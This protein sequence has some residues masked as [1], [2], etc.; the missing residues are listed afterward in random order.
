M[1]PPTVKLMSTNLPGHPNVFGGYICL[2]MLKPRLSTGPYDGWTSAYTT[3]SIL[4]QLQSFLLAEG[5]IDQDVGGKVKAHWSQES[6]DYVRENNSRYKL[7]IDGSIIHTHNDPFPPFTTD[8]PRDGDLAIQRIVETSSPSDNVHCWTDLPECITL[9]VTEYLHIEAL[10]V[11]R[12]VC[13]YWKRIDE[14]FNLFERRQIC[15]FHT[16][17]GIDDD[18]SLIFGIGIKVEH[19]ARKTGI[20]AIT[21]PLDILSETAFIEDEVRHSVWNHRFD[22]FLPLAIHRKHFERGIPSLQ[23][24]VYQVFGKNSGPVCLLDLFATAMN[25]MVVQLFTTQDDSHSSCNPQPVLHASETA[26]DGYCAF[27]HLLLRCS[28]RFPQIRAEAQR[29]VSIFLK[30]DEGRHKE[31]TPDIGRFLICLTLSRQGWDAVKYHVLKE[32]FARQVRWL[33]Q[34]KPKFGNI[35]PNRNVSK[36]RLTETFESARTGL[37]LTCFQIAFLDIAGRPSGTKGPQDVACAYDKRLGKPTALMRTQLLTKAKR[38]VALKNWPEF[39]RLTRADIT[40]SAQVHELLVQAVIASSKK[41]YHYQREPVQ[42][43]KAR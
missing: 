20:A 15:C 2:S 34:K 9:L 4:L 16:K 14:E 19:Y 18:P 12:N 7:T 10:P 26:L 32:S 42:K 38:I 22:Y 8:I 5:D 41:G 3:E 43:H 17:L 36:T 39:F 6:V 21:S 29:R 31:K 33:L 25:T 13:C 11:F 37:C 24:T 35:P 40:G 23:R 30:S 1:E 28:E 27:H